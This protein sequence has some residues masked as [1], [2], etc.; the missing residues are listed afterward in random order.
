MRAIVVWGRS[1]P[2][3][4]HVGAP[5]CR[6][7]KG[8]HMIH[9]LAATATLLAAWVGGEVDRTVPVTRE[10]G[11]G[12]PESPDKPTSLTK[13]PYLPPGWSGGQ[14][15]IAAARGSGAWILAALFGCFSGMSFMFKHIWD[16]LNQLDLP[17]TSPYG[18][19]WASANVWRAIIPDEH[20][21]DPYGSSVATA[22]DVY[23]GYHQTSQTSGATMRP[24]RSITGPAARPAVGNVA[25][26]PG[27]ATNFTS[28]LTNPGQENQDPALMVHCRWLDPRNHPGGA[29]A[30]G[31]G[32][33]QSP[34]LDQF[35][36]PV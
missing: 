34:L 36:R 32:S 18:N 20:G 24:P 29:N 30:Q 10:P 4:D 17:A 3:L 15:D 13:T 31:G 28:F 14:V 7:Q 35:R 21:F 23:R 33:P 22:A 26:V 1:T 2:V 9:L 16:G 19:N 12:S 5:T 25:S 8:N 11:T 6:P 27:T